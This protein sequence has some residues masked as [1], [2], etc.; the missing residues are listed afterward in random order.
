MATSGNPLAQAETW[1]GSGK[2]V[3]PAKPLGH[4]Y[5]KVKPLRE[6]HAALVTHT[7]DDSGWSHAIGQVGGRILARD[8]EVQQGKSIMGCLTIYVLRATIVPDT[9]GV[10]QQPS[11]F[12]FFWRMCCDI[13]PRVR[14]PAYPDD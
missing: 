10:S 8:G 7:H 11:K 3:F 13:L 4:S 1:S 9:Q 6:N 14:L 12:L 5:S 2:S